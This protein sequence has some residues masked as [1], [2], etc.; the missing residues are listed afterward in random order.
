MPEGVAQLDLRLGGG[1][2][3]GGHVS[4][5]LGGGE[6]VRHMSQ[7]YKVSSILLQEIH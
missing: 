4:V 7:I 2:V 1:G 6:D 5:A 3:D